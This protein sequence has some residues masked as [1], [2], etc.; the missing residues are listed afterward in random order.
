MAI[1]FVGLHVFFA[2]RASL[3]QMVICHKPGG[4][5]AVEFD[6]ADGGCQCEECEHCRARRAAPRPGPI[7]PGLEPCH[8]RHEVI[9]SD[10]G[11]SSLR[12]PDR[13]F[14]FDPASFPAEHRVEMPALLRARRGP[15]ESA[16]GPSP[17]PADRDSAHLRC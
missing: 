7:V 8:C 9:L 6:T 16:A 17:G 10:V 11:H 5:S 12:L 2:V 3:P 14:L 1:V 13:H 4:G 15:G